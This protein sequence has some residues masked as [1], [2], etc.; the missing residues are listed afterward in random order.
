M[1]CFLMTLQMQLDNVI[2]S[3]R[4]ICKLDVIMKRRFSLA[5][6]WFYAAR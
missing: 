2:N 6:K 4:H 1:N 5:D 3:L